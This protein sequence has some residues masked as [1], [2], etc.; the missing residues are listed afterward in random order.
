[1][2]AVCLLTAFAR[3]GILGRLLAGRN[4][5]GGTLPE[6]RGA[7]FMTVIQTTVTRPK[8]GRRHDAVAFAV[9]AAKLLERHG[10]AENRLLLAQPAGEATG[11]QV[12]TT[13]FD[14]GEAWGAFTDSLFHDQELETL[15]DRVYGEDSPIVMESMSI[16]TEIPLGRSGPSN[17]QP[18]VEAY[19]SRAVPGR[20]AAALELAV[21]VFDFVEANGGTA[22]RL[23]QL[24]N[25]GML[26]DCLVAS[27]EFENVKALGRMGDA[28]GADPKGQQI[29]EMLTG[30]S[31]PITPV[32]SGVYVEMPM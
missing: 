31:G 29:M 1:M 32:S 4:L 27:W 16:G 12:F 9:E 13:E 25:A 6:P 28:Y 26:T 24:S 3:P 2:D 19:I 5:G 8:P 14:S 21:A 23:M 10:G 7:E 17:R 20:F 30:P 22:C 18:V 11:G 15:L